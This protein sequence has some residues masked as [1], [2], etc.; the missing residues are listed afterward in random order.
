LS[1]R[2]DNVSWTHVSILIFL[3]S[4]DSSD[5]IRNAALLSARGLAGPPVSRLDG[6]RRF[7]VRRDDKGLLQLRRATVHDPRSNDGMPLEFLGQG[8]QERA[9][10][11]LVD[12]RGGRLDGGKFGIG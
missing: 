1:F 8:F 6:A 3:E 4:T 11:K 5:R 10:L 12:G 7:S 2:D 9:A